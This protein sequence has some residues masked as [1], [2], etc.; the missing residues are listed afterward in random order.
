MCCVKKC[1]NIHTHSQAI[2]DVTPLPY[3]DLFFYLFLLMLIG[4]VSLLCLGI[5]YL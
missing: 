4:S 3:F 1:A 2:L 5:L